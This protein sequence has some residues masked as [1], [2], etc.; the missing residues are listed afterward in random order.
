MYSVLEQNQNGNGTSLREQPQPV[1]PAN[2]T[3]AS[4]NGRSSFAQLLAEYEF[5]RPKRG[6]ILTGQVLRISDVVYL[7]VGSKRDAMV[8]HDEVAQLDQE[9]LDEL[10]VGDEFPVYVTETPRG[11]EQL[12]VSL[13]RGLQELDWDK[14]KA[15]QAEDASVEL[16]VTGHNKGGLLVEFRRIEGFVPNSHLPGLQRAWDSRRQTSYK[17]TQVGKT[18]PLKFIEVDRQGERLV[19]SATAAQ[20]EQQRQRLESLIEGKVVTGKVADLKPYGAFVDLDNGLTGLLH[21]SKIAW[22][23]LDHPADALQVGEE[24]EVRLDKIDLERGRISL[25]RQ[26][27]LPNPW[28]QFAAK[29]KV[30]E[31]IAGTV[32]AVVDFGAFVRVAP[33]IEGLLHKSDMDVPYEGEPADVLRPGDEILVRIVHLEPD[34]ERVG[35]SMRR[36]SAAEELEWMAHR[37]TVTSE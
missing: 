3:P 15:L 1:D 8:P 31:L 32:T 35:L 33:H 16:E 13:E 6:D 19:L 23:H 12:I 18:L 24:V 14:A 22:E 37:G 21:I 11:S 20:R 36:V 28:E 2:S 7:D 26:A 30:D 10:E 9:F 4:G 17:A 29:H 27:L 34:D 25:N 5:P